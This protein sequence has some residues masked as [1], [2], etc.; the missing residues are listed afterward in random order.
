MFLVS[1]FERGLGTTRREAWIRTIAFAGVLCATIILSLVFFPWRK[2]ETQTISLLPGTYLSSSEYVQSP[3][4]ITVEDERVFLALAEGHPSFISLNDR[5]TYITTVGD[6]SFFYGRGDNSPL[7][8]KVVDGT[9]QIHGST[10][11]RTVQRNYGD[12]AAVGFMFLL[13]AW[14]LVGVTVSR[15]KE[16]RF[17]VS[18]LFYPWA[19]LESWRRKGDCPA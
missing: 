15:L 12:I 19:L 16:D 1:I 17:F 18:L 5:V 14:I 6:S 3:N 8:Y 4:R 11:T 7:F 2:T 9:S 13:L 10:L